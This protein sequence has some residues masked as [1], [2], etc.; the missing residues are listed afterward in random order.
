MRRRLRYIWYLLK[1]KFWVLYYLIRI[2]YRLFFLGIRHD[3][4]K[5]SKHEFYPYAYAFYSDDGGKRLVFIGSEEFE[6]G[7]RHHYTHNKHHWQHWV[8]NGVAVDMPLKYIKEMAA[9][10]LA[11]SRSQNDNAFQWFKKNEESINMTERS[12]LLLEHYLRRFS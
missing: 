8:M 10:M 12:M 9:D 7:W 2:D 6:A 5:F 3:I 4:S 1:H 11:M